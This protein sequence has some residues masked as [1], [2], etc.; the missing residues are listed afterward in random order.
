MMKR[1]KEKN[2]D[3]ELNKNLHPKDG[4]AGA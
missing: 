4:F 1:E 3:R 2:G